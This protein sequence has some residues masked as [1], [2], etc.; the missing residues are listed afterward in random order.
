MI[1]THER[2]MGTLYPYS[3]SPFL[4][5]IDTT[6]ADIPEVK[7]PKTRKGKKFRTFRPQA[8]SDIYYP[9]QEKLLKRY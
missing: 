5:E 3:I 6:I 4:Q 1:P 9:R 8:V 2:I 7:V